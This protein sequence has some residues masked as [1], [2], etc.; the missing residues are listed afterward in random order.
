MFGRLQRNLIFP[1]AA[2]APTA[3]LDWRNAPFGAPT[4]RSGELRALRGPD[5]DRVAVM[6][7]A[8]FRGRS[9]GALETTSAAGLAPPVALF[10]YGNAMT[11]AYAE[12]PIALLR[13]LGLSVVAPDYCGYG[14]S[15]GVASEQGCYDAADAAYAHALD[16]A[17]GCAD[18]IVAVGW[19]LGAA[20]ALHLATKRAVAGVAALSAFTSMPAMMRKVTGLPL[21]FG[22]IA[23]AQFD[24]A[25]AIARIDRPILLVHGAA[26]AIVPMS[27]GQRLAE[28]GA[29]RRPSTVR[30]EALPDVGHNDLFDT[31]AAPLTRALRPFFD[32]L[33]PDSRAMADEAR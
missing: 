12:A 11:L 9:A 13:G 23:Q 6:T 29:R 3:S 32:R 30:F 4:E 26:D 16:C 28:I 20:V 31:G 24:N 15:D 27:M 1:G 10:F 18:R 7:G 14:F 33:F 2:T 17:E 19:S 8:P 22:A 21:P 5:G 25:R